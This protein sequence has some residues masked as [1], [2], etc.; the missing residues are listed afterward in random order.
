MK[1]TGVFL[2]ETGVVNRGDGIGNIATVKK[3]TTPDGIKIYFSPQ[4]YKRALWNNLQKN[5][6]WTLPLVTREGGVVQR[7]GTIIDSEEFDFGG[8]MVA[9]P[10][11]QRN[12][13]FYVD[14]GISINNFSGDMEFMTN[15]GLASMYGENETNIINRENFYGIYLLPFGIEINRIGIQEINLNVTF[16]Q[17]DNMESKIITIYSELGEGLTNQIENRLQEQLIGRVESIESQNN[18]ITI[19]LKRDEIKR[20]LQQLLLA[21]GEL[22]RQIEGS[23]RNLSPYFAVFSLDYATPKFLLF[24]KDK[25]RKREKITKD[26]LDQYAK[27]DGKTVIVATHEN[28]TQIVNDEIIAKIFPQAQNI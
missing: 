12:T 24:I 7:T 26:E 23:E 13:T 17:N 2:I 9:D 21:M 28:Y 25:L 4:S 14:Q 1:L 16:N 27:I 15:M 18:V 19:R 5:Y 3:I 10:K 11:Y 6:N 20:R 8:T 22:G